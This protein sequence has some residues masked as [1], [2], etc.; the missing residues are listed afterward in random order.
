MVIDEK[1]FL[2]IHSLVGKSQ[3]LDF[4]AIFFSEYS[5][6]FLMAGVL[7]IL[8]L[9]NDWKK[10][11]HYFSLISLSVILSRGILT[12]LIRFFYFRPRPFLALDFIPLI[13]KINEGAFPSGHA[14]FFFALSLPVYLINKKWG[15]YFIGTSILM[16]LARIFVGV[17]WPFDIFGGIAVAFISFYAIKSLLDK[18][19]G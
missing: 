6:Y 11:I 10:R 13:N 5:G 4:F 18:N 12:E 2:L 1:L 15:R 7:I 14:A 9:E 17:H 19:T 16:G 8:F 3:I